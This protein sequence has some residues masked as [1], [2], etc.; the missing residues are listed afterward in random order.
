VTG[1]SVLVEKPIVPKNPLTV[2]NPNTLPSTDWLAIA[3]SHLTAAKLLAG[4]ATP[5]PHEAIYLAGFALEVALK[6]KGLVENIA[7]DPTHDLEELLVRSQVLRKART[8]AVPA[9]AITRLG[10]PAP[11]YLDLF[12]FIKS[13][14]H[15]ELRYSVGTATPNAATEFATAVEEMVNWLWAA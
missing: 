10:F 4:H 3:Q 15:N 11:T 8:Q 9:A 1:L 6:G 14:W 12:I 2:R 13:Q 5:Q 7:V